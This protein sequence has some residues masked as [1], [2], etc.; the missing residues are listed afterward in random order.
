MGDNSGRQILSGYFVRSGGSFRHDDTFTIDDYYLKDEKNPILI[1][2]LPGRW[3]QRAQ[4]R[5]T[6][7]GNAEN[8]TP[9]NIGRMEREAC[10]TAFVMI[11][12]G[13]SSIHGLFSLATKCCHQKIVRYI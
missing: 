1:E 10:L 4:E 6:A 8:P 11:V 7:Q 2:L 5:S 9:G 12:A 13:Q 3:G